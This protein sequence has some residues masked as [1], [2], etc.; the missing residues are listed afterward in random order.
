MA[1]GTFAIAM[2]LSKLRGSRYLVFTV[3]EFLSDFGPTLALVVMILF[4]LLFTA[5]DVAFLYFIING[6]HRERLLQ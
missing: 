3:R 4:G 5:V 6:F 2:L 1:I